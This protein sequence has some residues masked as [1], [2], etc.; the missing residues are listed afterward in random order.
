MLATWLVR[1]YNA[2]LAESSADAGL[3]L[4][5]MSLGEA[6]IDNTC[7]AVYEPTLKGPLSTAAACCP[8]H[9]PYT[10]REW[11]RWLTSDRAVL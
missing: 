5:S 7:S 1:L 11:L 8:Y 9:P 4:S 10:M 6:G 2:D 3:Q